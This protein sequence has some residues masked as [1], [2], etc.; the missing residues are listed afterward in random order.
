M[1]DAIPLPLLSA[2]GLQWPYL[3][4]QCSLR[5]PEFR[6]LVSDPICQRPITHTTTAIRHNRLCRQLLLNYNLHCLH[7]DAKTIDQQHDLI[8]NGRQMV[9]PPGGLCSGCYS[10]DL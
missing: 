5:S 3:R 6:Q 1:Q 4:S 10:M 9:L 8:K 2:S 7:A